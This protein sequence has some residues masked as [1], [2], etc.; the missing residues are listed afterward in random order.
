M[1]L[2][3]KR[4]AILVEK[5]YHEI[6][7]FVPYYRL[8]EEGAIIDIIGIN[9]KKTYK[10]KIGELIV[11]VDKDI[12]E[13]SSS[14][15]DG[16]I[17]PGGYSPEYL[18]VSDKIIQFIQ[19]INSENKLVAAICHG[20]WVISS[21]KIIKD[22]MVTCHPYIRHDLINAGGIYIDENVVIDNNLITSRLPNDLP[23]FNREIIKYLL[24]QN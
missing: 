11:N 18:R 15:Y 16:V 6:E 12:S 19:N 23:F 21:S 17:I 7:F 10:G 4:I 13:I 24:K 2:Q 3:G 22:R 5:F 14:D 20:G 9:E 1:K 8:L